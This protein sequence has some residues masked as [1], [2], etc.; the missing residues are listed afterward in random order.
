MRQTPA[1]HTDEHD[2]LHRQISGRGARLIN[3]TVYWPVSLNHLLI[4][5]LKEY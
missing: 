3:I 2:S 4:F 1:D 5:Y